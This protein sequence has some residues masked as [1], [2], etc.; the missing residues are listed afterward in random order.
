MHNNSLNRRGESVM[1]RN[2][3]RRKT[4]RAIFAFLRRPAATWL[5]VLALLV[6]VIGFGAAPTAASPEQQAAVALSVAIGQQVSLCAQGEHSGAPDQTCPH[7]DDC[8]LCGFACSGAPAPL[9]RVFALLA[10]ERANPT[11]LHPDD[12]APARPPVRSFAARPRA[13][14]IL[15]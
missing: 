5:A 3:T 11:L 12:E 13:P 1:R 14:P 8:A 10:P 7:C 15:A 6:Q 4:G 2:Q 9:A